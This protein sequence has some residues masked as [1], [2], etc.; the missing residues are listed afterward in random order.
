[1]EGDLDL[2]DFEDLEEINLKVN[3][4]KK[5]TF[6]P[7]INEKLKILSLKRNNLL[8]KELDLTCFSRFSSLEILKIS[9]TSFS[10][11]LKPLEKLTKL[12]R[13]DIGGTDID[14]GLEYLPKGIEKIHCDSDDFPNLDNS[15][16]QVF[17]IHEELA[18]CDYDIKT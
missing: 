10:G 7:S 18:T 8:G 11:S 3:N 6:S 15:N 1:L 5:V 2:N 16:P 4:I 12:K 13:L 17:R 14:S 9:A